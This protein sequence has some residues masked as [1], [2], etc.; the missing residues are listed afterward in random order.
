MSDES[1]TAQNRRE[2]VKTRCEGCRDG[3]GC[4]D[5]SERVGEAC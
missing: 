4:R 1:K 5:A 3:A 2:F